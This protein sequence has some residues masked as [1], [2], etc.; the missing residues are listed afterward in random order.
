MAPLMHRF[1]SFVAASA[2]AIALCVGTA[3]AGLIAQG[4][5]VV[6]PASEREVTLRVSNT[7]GTPVLAQ[8]WIDDGRQDV[9]PEELQVPFSVTPAVTRVEPNGGAV[10]RIAYLKAPLPTDRESLFWL[11]ILEVPP[12]DEDENNALQFS[13]RSRFKLFFRPS[14]LKSVDSAAG[15]LQWKFLESG[16]AGK[17]TVVQVNNPALLRFVRQRR[18]DCR[19]PC[20]VRGKGNGRAILDEGVRLAGKSEEHGSRFRQI[21]SHQR[22]RWPQY[23]R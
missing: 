1:H 17:K 2:V 13:F 12:R 10:L 14:Q 4:T 19:W 15:K 7:S 11:N 16:G 20:H 23:P 22:L 6:F 21:R 18:I 3:H 8:A 9:P 5:R